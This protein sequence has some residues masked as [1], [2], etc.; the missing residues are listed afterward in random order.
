ML[1][2]GPHGGSMSSYGEG[3]GPGASG[4]DFSL[5]LNYSYN[6]Y[7]HIGPPIFDPRLDRIIDLL[8]GNINVPV[9]GPQGL[10]GRLRAN[11][12][13]R[14]FGYTTTPW[15]GSL[16]FLGPQKFQAGFDVSPRGGMLSFSG[17]DI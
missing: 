12:P 15:E 5:P 11:I 1:A 9:Q 17:S 4:M 13:N 2:Q 3:L 16:P 7:E 8:K 6:P 14:T 10:I